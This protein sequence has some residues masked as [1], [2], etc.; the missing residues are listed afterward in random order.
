MEKNVCG[1]EILYNVRIYG[2]KMEKDGEFKFLMIN[3]FLLKYEILE[4]NS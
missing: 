3:S 2:G 4:I 1:N